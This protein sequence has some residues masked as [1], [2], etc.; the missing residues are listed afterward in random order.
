M[1]GLDGDLGGIS[2]EPF[3]EKAELRFGLGEL[4]PEEDV[5]VAESLLATVTVGGT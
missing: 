1:S 4:D 5:S 2:G 3:T